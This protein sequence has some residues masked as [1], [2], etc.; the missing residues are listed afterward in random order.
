MLGV[1]TVFP[2]YNYISNR[3]NLN[4]WYNDV[5]TYQED[6][7]LGVEENVYNFFSI[8][9]R[10]FSIHYRFGILLNTVLFTQ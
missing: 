6:G 10:P 8:Y 7:S 9:N 5:P 4:A 2:Q 1:N 3:Q